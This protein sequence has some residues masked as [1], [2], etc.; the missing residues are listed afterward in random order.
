MP[1][2]LNP[3]DF[4]FVTLL[5]NVPGKERDPLTIGWNGREYKLEVGK[6]THVPLEAAT[7]SFGDPRS[8]NV[9]QA[10]PIGDPQMGE[11][12]FIPDRPAEVRR[13]RLRYAIL[14]GN[15]STFE[16]V[17]GQVM[18]P[19]VS[20]ETVDGEELTTVFNDPTADTVTRT[21]PTV[22]QSADTQATI[23]HLTKQVEALRAMVERNASENPNPSLDAL[24]S[25][26]ASTPSLEDLFNSSSGSGD[27]DTFDSLPEENP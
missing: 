6:R 8:T 26:D 16:N 7:N 24:P 3:G 21:A 20:I 12:L 1:P 9:A 17:S 13:L 11:K 18:V 14:D 23:D 25:D 2:V 5:S 4:V 19:S 22:Q 10:I 15:D 27:G